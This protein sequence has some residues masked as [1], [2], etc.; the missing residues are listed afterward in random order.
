[1][2]LFFR[3]SFKFGPLRFNA[4]SGGLGVSTGI[5]GARL[6]LG[7]KGPYLA[8]G[9]K[10]VYYRQSL[11]NGKRTVG[12]GGLLPMAVFFMVLATLFLIFLIIGS[13]A[14]WLR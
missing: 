8:G 5:K 4:G 13:T 12:A 9:T 7:R 6:G 14:W 3:K 11:A 1:M 10:G 2:G